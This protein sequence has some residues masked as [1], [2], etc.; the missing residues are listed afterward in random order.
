MCCLE[1]FP[2]LPFGFHS[3]V[4]CDLT[5]ARRDGIPLTLK[6]HVP[7][8]CLYS[9]CCGHFSCCC[10][11][12]ENSGPSFSSQPRPLATEGS[13]DIVSARLIHL[14]V[15]KPCCA[16]PPRQGGPAILSCPPTAVG[17]PGC[18]VLRVSRRHLLQ[19][20]GDMLFSLPPAPKSLL[21]PWLSASHRSALSSTCHFRKH[22]SFP[23]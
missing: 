6:G 7:A 13:A 1:G 15:T 12:D 5:Q 18:L 10:S 22:P 20:G 11:R 4:T 3:E 9:K 16:L 17:F 8:P 23:E 2:C 21:F 14:P 19:R